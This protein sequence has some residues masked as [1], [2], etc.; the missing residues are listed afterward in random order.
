MRKVTVR[1]G[2]KGIEAITPQVAER[3]E[4][5]IELDQRIG[6]EPVDP[7]AP[8]RFHRDEPRVMEHPEVPADGRSGN[9]ESG[10]DLPGRH[11]LS[12]QHDDDLSSNRIDEDCERLHDRNVTRE[13][14]IPTLRVR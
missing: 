8:D 10:R 9:R 14:R 3:L 12:S 7:S 5:G 4:L 13:L 11:G 2:L 1:L 6:F